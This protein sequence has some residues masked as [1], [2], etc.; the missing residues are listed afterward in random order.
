[1]APAGSP[2]RAST[3]TARRQRF[4]ELETYRGVAA[5]LLIV[6]HAYQFSREG[7]GAERYLYE[8]SPLHTIF[9]GLVGTTWFFA[10]SGFLI[11]LPFARALVNQS[12]QESV[13]GF[14]I[15]PEPEA[16]PRNAVLLVLT[17]ILVASIIYKVIEMPFM[18]LRKIFTRDG[19]RRDPYA[20]AYAIDDAD[21]RSVPAY[22]GPPL[23][24]P[25]HARAILLKNN[26][27]T[28]GG[29]HREQ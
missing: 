28:A 1:M 21:V 10:L 12:G 3:A 4:T 22:A 16:F 9:T 20:G 29:K 23:Q 8:G 5:I 6:F 18:E 26:D 24:L 27:G 19:R 2:V 25:G 7:T 15:S 17:T 14:L 11:F 13:R